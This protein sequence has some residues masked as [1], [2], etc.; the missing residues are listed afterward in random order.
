MV[1]RRSWARDFE[2]SV[3][4]N[5]DWPVLISGG[6]SWFSFASEPNVI[7][8]LD[9]PAGSGRSGRQRAWSLLRLENG[10]D[11]LV[12]AL[13]AGHRGELRAVLDRIPAQA[14]LWSGGGNDLIGADLLP[15]LLPYRAGAKPAECIHAERLER[16]LRRLEDFYRELVD[17]VLDDGG[18]LTL[19]LN[20]YDYP[21]PCEKPVKLLGS[22]LTG[23]WLGPAFRER[24][25]PPGHPLEREVP[26]LLIDRFCAMVDRIAAG[27]RGRLVRVETRGAVGADWADEIHPNSDAARRVA[28]RFERAL[29][30][31]GVKA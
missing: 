27:C 17:L 14:L 6:D 4:D 30:R 21:Q 5:P 22:K 1:Y 12:T 2:R 11:E 25:Y 18:D 29:N 28:E 15:L 10:S 7:D 16:R 13:S 24:G 9:D 31:R 19:F 26:R 3:R 8:I 20:S 23:P